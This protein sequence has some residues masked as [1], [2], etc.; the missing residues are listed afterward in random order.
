MPSKV[1]ITGGAGFI[2]SHLAEYLVKRG[3]HVS[4]IDNLS[5]GS[6]SNIRQLQKH[7]NFESTIGSVTDDHIL[8]RLISSVDEVYHLAAAVGVKLIMD[9]PV[10]TIMTNVRGAENV[11]KLCTYHQ[12]KVFMCSTSEIY[13]KTLQNQADRTP[14]REDGDCTIGATSRRRWA[15]ACTKAI[16]EFLALAYYAERNLQ[17]VIAR[18]FN[19]V[20]PRQTGQYGMVVPIFVQQ[21]LRGDPISVHGDGE[22]TRFFTHV[23]DAINAMVKLMDTP[24][25]IGQVFNIGGEEEVTIN[26]LAERIRTMAQ[27][28]STITHTPH[29]EVYGKEFEDMRHRKPDIRKLCTVSGYESQ[30][31]L[32][33]ILLSV[34]DH[35][36]ATVE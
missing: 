12:K 19:T 34:I 16:D 10:D 27:S 22:Q 11:L 36:R 32:D 20:G 14:L 5:T 23:N 15:Y 1:L 31:C 26:Q 17:V 30:Y 9:H 29:E 24:Q 25:A 21:A 6:S 28:N 18:L 7:G 3:S 13:G 35:F 4:V 8:D 33:D 2:G